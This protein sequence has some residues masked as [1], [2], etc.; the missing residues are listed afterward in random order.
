M[1]DVLYLKKRE[2]FP[3]SQINT[4]AKEEILCLLVVTTNDMIAKPKFVIMSVI[5]A[6]GKDIFVGESA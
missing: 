4:I 2:S 1:E 5:N 3:R 6:W